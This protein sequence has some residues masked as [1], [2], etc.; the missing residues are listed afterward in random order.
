M[1]SPDNFSTEAF[2]EL[3]KNFSIEKHAEK[4]EQFKDNKEFKKQVSHELGQTFVT[5][6][7]I[8]EILEV[9]MEQA[10]QEAISALD[11]ECEESECEDKNC[12]DKNCDSEC[13]DC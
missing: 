10:V 12:E 7:T 2:Q 9:D 1:I 3:L 11:A 8:A 5:M 4:L 13:T 6:L